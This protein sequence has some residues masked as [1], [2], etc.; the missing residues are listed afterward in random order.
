MRFL[1]RLYHHPHPH[2]PSEE[3]DHKVELQCKLKVLEIINLTGS[4]SGFPLTYLGFR[5]SLGRRTNYPNWLIGSSVRI[6]IFASLL[7][8]TA[9]AHT[10]HQSATSMPE[11][12][13]SYFDAQGTATISAQARE[14]LAHSLTNPASAA[15]IAEKRAQTDA[16]QARDSAANLAMYPAK[17]SSSVIAGVPVRIV[18][19][20]SGVPQIKA[21]RV[22]INLHGGGFTTDSGSLT[23][24][25]SRDG[26]G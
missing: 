10:V 24:R 2:P 11:T 13:E 25:G 15:T 9:C 23:S 19:P 1:H 22:L 3:Q 6:V 18:T 8:L 26:A 5:L 21:D 7:A 14:Y 4:L 16:A 12:D 20:A 17:V